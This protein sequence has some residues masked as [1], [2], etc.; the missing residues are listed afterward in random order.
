MTN[1]HNAEKITCHCKSM[2][3]ETPLRLNI[4]L[5]KIFLKSGSLRVMKKF[6]ESALTQIS[7]EFGAI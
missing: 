5:R 1:S 2:Y 6:D 3:C 4:S 7:Q